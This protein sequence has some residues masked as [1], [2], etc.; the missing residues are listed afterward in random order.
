MV[1]TGRARRVSPGVTFYP[2]AG[3]IV[4]ELGFDERK[5]LFEMAVLRGHMVAAIASLAIRAA[6]H[7]EGVRLVL[8][9]GRSRGD[10]MHYLCL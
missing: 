8:F 4:S 6:V 7:E 9:T 3:L 2:K 5:G 1:V 10:L